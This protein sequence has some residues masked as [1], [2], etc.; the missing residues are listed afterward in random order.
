[1]PLRAQPDTSFELRLVAFDVAAAHR[2]AADAAA[3]AAAKRAAA[4]KAAAAKAAAAALAAKATV[5]RTAAQQPAA[6]AYAGTN[7]VWMPSL[8]MSRSVSSFS[9]TR[10]APPV[11]LVYRWGCAGSNNVYLFGHA[12][13]VMKPLHDGY[14]AG[15]VKK[16]M[17]VVYADG[18]GRIHRFKVTEIRIVTP[19]NI[20][21]A[22]AAQSRTSMTL[23]TCLG[24]R[25][26]RRLLV[27]LVEYR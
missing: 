24:A 27:R 2:Q 13:G 5:A 25:S 9:C 12:W 19:D 4:A 8:G 20:G 18:R 23:Q 17:I 6:T 1:L 10:S 11:N 3:A 26:E 14:L 22:I 15:K 21:W 16:G 7:H